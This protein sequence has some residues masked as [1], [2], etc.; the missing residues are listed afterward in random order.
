MKPMLTLMLTLTLSG[1]GLAQPG[2]PN[3][4]VQGRRGSVNLGITADGR[5]EVNATGQRGSV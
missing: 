5:A 1:L 4:Q 3:V 2:G